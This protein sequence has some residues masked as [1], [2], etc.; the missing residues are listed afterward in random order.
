LENNP[1][2]LVCP[3]DWGIGHA[4]RCVPVIRELLCQNAN[5]II[6]ADG[7]PL[8]FLKVEF[9]GIQF[10]S[11]PGYK[12]SYPNR[13]SMTLK[14]LV[15]APQ[16]LKGISQ[17]RKLLD[18]IISN[19]NING[20]ISDNRFGLSTKKVPCVFITHQLRIK[21]PRL[22]AILKPLL[23][24]INTNYISKYDECWVPDFPDEP[25]LSGELSHLKNLPPKI[26]FIG[27]LS[28][29]TYLTAIENE[30]VI[31]ENSVNNFLVILSGPEPQ[32][33]ILEY[34]ILN[35]LKSNKYS[36]IVVKGKP[37]LNQDVIID[38]RIKVYP[39]LN[40]ESLR[41]AILESSV[42][43]SRPGYS[44]LMDLAVFGKKAI[45]IPTPG[46][47]E[48]EYLAK[49]CLGKKWFYSMN[50]NQFDLSKALKNTENFTGFKRA[51][52]PEVLSSRI[53][54]WLL[55]L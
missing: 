12:F 20:V 51:A 53:S 26:Y 23:H 4:T 29:F 31:K 39:H 52:D 10:I 40:S 25:N 7:K 17:E 32:R 13:G 8:A 42:V 15:Q 36:A 50:Q 27:P 54:S 49:Y 35:Q 41:K 5:V 55:S 45:F 1:N 48:Q 47:T 46:Q 21:V 6:A 43:L 28:R 22:L 16:I 18:Q 44:T 11:F 3:L 30:W 37:E 9:P 14:M 24:W 38:G 2:I 33:T 19:Y 34:N